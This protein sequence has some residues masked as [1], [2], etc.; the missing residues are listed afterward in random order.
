MQNPRG[1]NWQPL[2]GNPALITGLKLR[3]ENGVRPAATLAHGAAATK[4][5]AAATLHQHTHPRPPS[6]T[7]PL[8]QLSGSPMRTRIAGDGA[9]IGRGG[10]GRILTGGELQSQCKGTRARPFYKRAG[11]EVSDHPFDRPCSSAASPPPLSPPKCAPVDCAGIPLHVYKHIAE[12]QSYEREIEIVSFLLRRVGAAALRRYT[13]YVPEQQRQQQQ[14]TSYFAPTTG[15]YI[16]LRY[17]SGQSA[18]GIAQTPYASDAGSGGPLRALAELVRTF[19][20]A[21]DLLHSVRVCHMDAKLENML[22]GADDRFYLSDFGLSQ[23]VAEGHPVEPAGTPAYSSPLL[24]FRPSADVEKVRQGLWKAA[25]GPDKTGAGIEP[26]LELYRRLHRTRGQAAAAN[27]RLLDFHAMGASIAYSVLVAFHRKQVGLKVGAV[28]L[29][30]AR[31]LMADPDD[32]SA[33]A[34]GQQRTAKDMND[35]LHAHLTQWM[36]RHAKRSKND[37]DQARALA[38]VQH[39]R[40]VFGRFHDWRDGGGSAPGQGIARPP[41][42]SM[43]STVGQGTFKGLG[44]GL[45]ANLQ[46]K[47]V[48]MPQ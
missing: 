12:K 28:M 16:P 27:F 8:R 31:T 46:T 14:L 5:G 44:G 25:H 20:E 39:S 23:V 32:P 7:R 15:A 1:S 3:T 36:R 22:S 38:D 11:S 35:R 18:E 40:A 10:Y 41:V 48:L 42:K 29:S 4:H 21:C 43:S 17:I 26:G 24:H 45:S 47:P 9:E 34:G 13:P 6:G 33:S 19:L 37:A 30:F 2:G